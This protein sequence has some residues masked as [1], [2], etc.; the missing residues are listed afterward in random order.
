MFIKISFTIFIDSVRGGE[1]DKRFI[2]NIIINVDIAYFTNICF[3][4]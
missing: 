1:K 3:G 4:A 2:E